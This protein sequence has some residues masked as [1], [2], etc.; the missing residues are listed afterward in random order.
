[1][2]TKELSISAL[3]DRLVG[4]TMWGISS[5]EKSSIVNSEEDWQVGDVYE[6]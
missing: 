5:E 4:D 1:M 2:D 3:G 6:P